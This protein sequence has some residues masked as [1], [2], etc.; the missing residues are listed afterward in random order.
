MGGPEDVVTL[1]LDN[2]GASDFLF[3]SLL[4]LQRLLDLD[5]DLGVLEQ[6]VADDFFDG[7]RIW[8]L[9]W[10]TTA[11]SSAATVAGRAAK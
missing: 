5:D 3:G 7:L 11:G 9:T 1:G 8:L 2:G 4:F 10:D 6:V